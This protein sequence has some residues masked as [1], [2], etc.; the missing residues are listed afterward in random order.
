MRS[1]ATSTDRF[2]CGRLASRMAMAKTRLA[3]MMMKNTAP[4]CEMARRMREV[5][6]TTMPTA[7]AAPTG[8][9][10]GSMNRLRISRLS[11]GSPVARSDQA[12][13]VHSK[14]ATTSPMQPMTSSGVETVAPTTT[15]PTDIAASTGQKLRPNG[16]AMR[17]STSPVTSPVARSTFAPSISATASAEPSRKALHMPPKTSMVPANAMRTE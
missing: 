7:I 11:A 2:S 8:I 1:T 12:R 10:S 17:R 5:A 13:T 6:N 4:I 14:P 3:T 15:A 9:S 16:V